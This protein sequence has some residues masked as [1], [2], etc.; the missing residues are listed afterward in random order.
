VKAGSVGVA[1]G[2]QRP[3]TVISNQQPV[4]LFLGQEPHQHTVT[5]FIARCGKFS[6]GKLPSTMRQVL[7][8]GKMFHDK[9]PRFLD[10][11][12][13]RIALTVC[14]IALTQRTFPAK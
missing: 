10:V 11:S 5:Y 4:G 12:L 2:I 14:P 9:G 3:V 8:M 1:L 13:R 6:L 7:L